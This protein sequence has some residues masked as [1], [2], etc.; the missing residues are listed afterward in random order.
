MVGSS[1]WRTRFTPAVAHKFSCIFDASFDVELLS[2]LLLDMTTGTSVAMAAVV[3]VQGVEALLPA[4][5]V[6]S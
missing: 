4:G 6:E 3:S 2:L 1:E 5:S